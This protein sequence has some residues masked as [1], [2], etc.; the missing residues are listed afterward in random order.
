MKLFNLRA[1]TTMNEN[2]KIFNFVIL[3]PLEVH[4]VGGSL[5][6]GEGE[7]EWTN[8]YCAASIW[9][10]WQEII[11]S[12]FFKLSWSFCSEPLWQNLKSAATLTKWTTYPPSPLPLL[13]PS[14]LLVCNNAHPLTLFGKE[15][16]PIT[17]RRWG[18]RGQRISRNFAEACEG[19]E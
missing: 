7:S 5:S 18:R 11:F 12:H 10:I 8:F 15:S 6:G 3:E 19:M 9:L 4:C 14:T 13:P 1:T 17:R 16:M 2:P